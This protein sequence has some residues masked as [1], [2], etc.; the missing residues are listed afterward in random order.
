MHPATS[1]K[2]SNAGNLYLAF[3]GLLLVAMG[4][5]FI[6]IMGLSY[7][8][9]E[10]TRSWQEVPCKILT[11]KRAKIVIPN[12]N[13]EYQWQGSFSYEIDGKQYVSNRLEVRGAKRTTKIEK[14]DKLTETYQAGRQKVC[15]VHPEDHSYA[16]LQHDSKG[17]GYS[18]WFPGLFAIGGLGMIVGAVKKWNR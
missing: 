3:L 1:E 15:F 11:S 13:V 4:G 7:K 9:A 8:N 12:R 2:K 16:I 14:V 18:I 17:A 10:R 5:F 6:W